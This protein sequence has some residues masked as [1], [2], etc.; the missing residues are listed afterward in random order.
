MIL[1][2]EFNTLT[3]YRLLYTI[4]EVTKLPAMRFDFLVQNLPDFVRGQSISGY[5]EE[6][7]NK[8]TYGKFKPEDDSLFNEHLKG[9]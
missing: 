7:I 4:R 2:I 3:F 1:D 9:A 5:L 6:D 8:A